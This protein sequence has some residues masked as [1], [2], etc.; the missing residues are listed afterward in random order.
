MAAEKAFAKMFREAFDSSRE[1]NIKDHIDLYIR[2][3]VKSV[4]YDAKENNIYCV[5][6]KNIHGNDGWL[7][8]KADFI[9]FDT[10]YQHW[11][12]TER[13]TLLDFINKNLIDK[14]RI[15]YVDKAPYKLYRRTGQKDIMT[16][17]PYHDLLSI[18]TIIPK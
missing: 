1:E 11:I 3:D 17:I 5:E 10:P 14:D 4:T 9:A 13:E 18:S 8:G 6:I 12:V 15:S 7:V 2:Y 16:F